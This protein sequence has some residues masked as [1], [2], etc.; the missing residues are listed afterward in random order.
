[1]VEEL[2]LAAPKVAV[3]V[4]SPVALSLRG[5]QE[6]VVPPFEPPDPDRLPDLPTLRR[7]EAVQLFA[8]RAREVDPGFKVIEDNDTLRTGTK[9]QVARLTEAFL[10]MKKFDLAEL[11]RAYEGS[12]A[13]GGG[14]R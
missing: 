2:L 14:E 9:E 1:M 13:R 12:D 6:Y 7:V 5:E 4:T 8:E 11:Q 10:K 3:L